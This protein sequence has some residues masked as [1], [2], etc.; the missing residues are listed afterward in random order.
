MFIVRDIHTDIILLY[1]EIRGS[2][3]I[4]DNFHMT[5]H[6]YRNVHLKTNL[7]ASYFYADYIK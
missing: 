1:R 6:P 7:T 4:I 3:L 5:S 2:V